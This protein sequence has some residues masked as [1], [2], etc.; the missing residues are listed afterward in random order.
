MIISAQGHN[1]RNALTC[2]RLVGGLKRA[3][4]RE[5][6]RSGGEDGLYRVHLH[7]GHIV[8]VA[9]IKRSA[10]SANVIEL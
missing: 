3:N 6:L 2:A 10:S 1:V 7:G 4:T 5:V 9:V 8:E